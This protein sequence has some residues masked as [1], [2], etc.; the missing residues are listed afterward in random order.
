M[1]FGIDTSLGWL[2]G[3]LMCGNAFF[4]CILMLCHPEFKSGHLTATMDP[5]ANYTGAGEVRCF[6]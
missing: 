3:C 1:D 6:I 2:V 5:T 4:N